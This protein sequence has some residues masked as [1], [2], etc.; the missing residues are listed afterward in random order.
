MN[1]GFSSKEDKFTGVVFYS[2]GFYQTW[3]ASFTSEKIF[4]GD[5]VRNFN[6]ETKTGKFEVKIETPTSMTMS[7]FNINGI[8]TGEYKNVKVK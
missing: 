4:S 3:F 8:K 2:S 6:P 7:M 1:F 5:F